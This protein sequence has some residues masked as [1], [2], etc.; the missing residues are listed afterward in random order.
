MVLVEIVYELF[1]EY[2]KLVFFQEFLN[3]IVFL[4]GVIKEEFG[5]CIV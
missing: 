3:E 1:E 2:K 4:F 5:D